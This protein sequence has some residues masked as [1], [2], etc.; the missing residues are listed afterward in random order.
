M[1]ESEIESVTPETTDTPESVEASTGDPG[2]A[3]QAKIE[4]LLDLESVEKFRLDGR[5]MTLKD[6]RAERMMQSDYTRKTQEIAQERKYYDNLSADLDSVRRNPSLAAKFKELY[7]AKFH[8]YLGYVSHPNQSSQVQSQQDQ[9]ISDQQTQRLPDH[10]KLEQRLNEI[11]SDWNER[12]VQAAEAELNAIYS[13]N[14]TKYP[15]ADEEAVTAR[16]QSLL[17]RIREENGPK[18]RITEDQWDRL[19]KATHDKNEKAAKVYYA[20]QVKKQTQANARGKD[21]AQGGGIPGQAPKQARNVKEA[22]E[23]LR[24][25]L[26][27]N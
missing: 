13:K 1:F 23:S 11:E 10:S 2:A 9:S 27:N 26:E 12:K 16:A 5:E 7:P 3:E 17:S 6:L 15:M 4:A 21:A 14:L 24:H 18:A 22:S 20:E 8:S 19:F 25:H